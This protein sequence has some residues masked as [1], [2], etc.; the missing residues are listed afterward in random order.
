MRAFVHIGCRLEAPGAIALDRC[1]TDDNAVVQHLNG[2]DFGIGRL[3]TEGR[4]AVVRDA[5]VGDGALDVAHVITQDGV[6]HGGSGRWLCLREVSLVHQQFCSVSCRVRERSLGYQSQIG[7]GEQRTARYLGA[8]GLTG[9]GGLELAAIQQ[10]HDL[11]VGGIGRHASQRAADGDVTLRLSLVDDVVAGDVVDRQLG[12]GH[13]RR[14]S[15]GQIGLLRFQCG[16]VASRVGEGGLDVHGQVRVGEQCAAGHLGGPGVALQRGL[17]LAAVDQH[18]DLRVGGVG[19]HASQRAADDHVALRLSLVDDVVIRDVVDRQLSVGHHRSDCVGLIGLLRCQ[20][21]GVASRVGEGGLDVHGQIR[22]AEQ[23]AAGH[24]GTPGIARHGCGIVVSIDGHHH[25][26]TH[27][28]CRHIGE[29]AG[30]GHVSLGLGQIDDVVVSDV[31]NDQLGVDHDRGRRIQNECERCARC[32][33]VAHGVHGGRGEHVF[34][35]GCRFRVERVGPCTLVVDGGRSHQDAVVIDIDLVA[36]SAG[37]G[38]R[39]R[40]IVRDRT[41]WQHAL[42]WA[43]V[44][45]EAR[46]RRNTRCLGIDLQRE[47]RCCD[48]AC[49][50]DGIDRVVMQ[51][52]RLLWQLDGPLAAGVCSGCGHFLAIFQDGH[53]GARCRRTGELGTCVVRGTTA[54]DFASDGSH[55]VGHA[56]DRQR[57]LRQVEREVERIALHADVV[58]L[59]CQC[60]RD[61]VSAFRQSRRRL[62]APLAFAIHSGGADQ[63]AVVVDLDLGTSFTRALDDRLSVIHH[64]AVGYHA[65]YVAS[66]VHD[67]DLLWLCWSGD[68][69]HQVE[70]QR[71]CTDLTCHVGGCGDETVCA[72]RQ[73]G[74]RD[75]PGALRSGLGLAHQHAGA[76]VGHVVELHQSARYCGALQ[77]RRRIVGDQRGDCLCPCKIRVHI[78]LRRTTYFCSN[79][80][81]Q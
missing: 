32:A 14:C 75:N 41:A 31:V 39:G 30:N 78:I 6:I 44:I 40:R 34:A 55:I 11:R 81:A 57:H 12:V 2:G 51:T 8:P 58:S 23:R 80:V 36:R 62:I 63:H 45:D 74:G 61:A 50:V 19:G 20:R 27:R 60:R 4:L 22:I 28:V 53:L 26:G 73:Q 52:I 64:A 72:L 65:H 77:C 54:G 10:H 67:L 5:A 38:Q 47:L 21:G 15:V 46:D 17:E 25:L 33:L 66:V 18:H 16:G 1:F 70:R 43:H 79:P 59:V 49:C 56:G 35:A 76:I 48:I 9:E 71:R 42:L 37:A 29:L 13:S 3:A 69:H 7:V 68:V 24:L